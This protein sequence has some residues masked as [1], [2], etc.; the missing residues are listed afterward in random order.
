MD[1]EVMIR[2]PVL[3]A[4]TG[5]G[6]FRNSSHEAP[7]YKATAC[8]ELPMNHEAEKHRQSKPSQYLLLSRTRNFL[9]YCLFSVVL[10]HVKMPSHSTAGLDKL[11]DRTSDIRAGLLVRSSNRLIT[12]SVLSRHF[13]VP[14][15]FPPPSAHPHDSLASLAGIMPSLRQRCYA[16]I[17]TSSSC[18]IRLRLVST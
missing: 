15:T 14:P 11:R 8:S 6:W 2:R 10:L 18:E 16:D 13:H 12:C 17:F 5:V 9:S 4:W 1:G 3:I 7:R